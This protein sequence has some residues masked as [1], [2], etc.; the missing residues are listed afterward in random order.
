M[1]ALDWDRSRFPNPEQMIEDFKTIGVQTILI[2]EPYFMKGL[3]N[4][5]E[6]NS[7]G[8][9][10]K[11]GRGKTITFPFWTGADAALLDLTN[12]AAQEWLWKKLKPICDGGVG[13]WWSDLGEPE[14]HP[15]EM[16]HHLGG[17][18]KVHNIFN[19]LWAK[20]VFEKYREH[21]PE[22]RLFNLT[23]S[24]TAG[25]Q[26]YA[27]FPWSGDVRRTFAGLALQPSIMMSMGMSGIAY[28]HSDIGGFTYGDPV[29]Q[30]ELYARWM[31]FGVF[32]PIVRAHGSGLPT[33]PYRFGDR[34]EKICREYIKLR[35]RLL[36]YTYSYVH[37]NS[38]TGLPI[39]RPLV[40][41]YPEDPEVAGLSS[42]YLWGEW[43]LVAPV[44]QANQNTREVYLPAGEWVDY[45]TKKKYDGGN[46][47]T[48]DAPLERLPLF[49]KSGA[50]L[51]MQNAHRSTSHTSQ[52]T[53]TL[54]IYPADSSSFSLYEDDG[55]TLAYSRGEFGVTTLT[56][57]SDSGLIS[58][59]CGK[60]TGKYQGKP[61][62]RLYVMQMQQILAA[63]DSIKHE[64]EKFSQYQT[65]AALEASGAG[66]WHD[67]T[68]KVLTVQKKVDTS[69]DYILQIYY[70][71]F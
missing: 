7:K 52:D 62:D 23:R 1:G 56:C 58:V 40:L 20:T 30:P 18:A 34:V 8:L 11:D 35:Y 49:V 53:L 71:N 19:L 64:K 45:W 39:A 57:K 12:P 50:I 3:K 54:E 69:A 59:V 13:G 22:T 66:W 37:E 47:I 42:E 14:N 70:S 36:P 67:P 10:S 43:L 33:E 55:K 17:A 6:A 32:S 26:R 51:P 27:A 9:F 29:T 31:Q 46:T 5:D 28:Q 15:E 2:H 63:P 16:T 25:M 38:Q 48:V 65:R 21:Y 24:G 41:E 61:L 4:F 60:A 44:M 68:H